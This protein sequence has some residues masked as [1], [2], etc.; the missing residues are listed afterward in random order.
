MVYLSD[1]A[2]DSLPQINLDVLPS[3][4]LILNLYLGLRQVD[5]E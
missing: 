1:V 5:I 3:L 2:V 4:G